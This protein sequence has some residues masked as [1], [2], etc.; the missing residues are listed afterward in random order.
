MLPLNYFSCQKSIHFL[1]LLGQLQAT[2]QSIKNG[3]GPR[4]TPA[5]TTSTRYRK[6]NI[7]FH[8]FI[9]IRHMIA[10]ISEHSFSFV[11]RD[12][13]KW[14]WCCERELTPLFRKLG[15]LLQP[16]SNT[17]IISKKPFYIFRTTHKS[18]FLNR[19]LVHFQGLVIIF[20][21]P[22]N[23]FIGIHRWIV[24]EHSNLVKATTDLHQ[25]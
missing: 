1:C 11:F 25:K 16:D 9:I 6:E 12:V 13:L 7:G 23:I 8:F 15:V 2:L 10:D 5:N 24:L 3:N 22:I 4:T 18:T 17:N 21:K 19:I 20:C 14:W